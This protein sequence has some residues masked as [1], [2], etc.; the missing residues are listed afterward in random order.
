[1]IRKSTFALAAHAAS[2]AIA[3]IAFSHNTAS[4]TE[5]GVSIDPPGVEST[6]SSAL[7]PPGV[8][9][10]TYF[11]DYQASKARDNNGNVVT[12]PGFKIHVDAVVNRFVWVTN[13]QFA[14]ASIAFQAV[15]PVARVKVNAAP[16]FSQAKTGLGDST[17]GVG[18][19]WHFSE[20][21]HALGAL[22]L[23]IPTGRYD[24]NDLANIGTNHWAVSPKFGVTYMQK[25]GFN[26]DFRNTLVFNTKNT[27]TDYRSGVEWF[28]DYTAGW[29]FGNGLTVGVAGYYYQQLT[30][31]RQAGQ[32]LAGSKGRAFAIGPSIRYDTGKG[33]MLS[34]KL[35][36]ES[37]VRNRAEG[38]SFW[39]RAVYAF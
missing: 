26:G 36:K 31:D 17:L 34:A 29:G 22:D 5:G 27:D 25:S 35:E 12:G 21:F 3:T 33:L 6:V 11:R 28:T 7:P 32:S 23:D 13:E 4:A 30:N 1:M 15:I 14:G 39:M 38:K 10:M 24:K 9:G 20:K 37:S 16:G 2:A 18:L 8:Y 19:A